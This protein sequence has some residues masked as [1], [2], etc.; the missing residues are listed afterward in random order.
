VLQRQEF[1]TGSKMLDNLFYDLLDR[2]SGI[3][4]KGEGDAFLAYAKEQYGLSNIAYLGVNIPHPTHGQHYVQCTY[5]DAWVKHYV[6]S[7]FVS[8]DPV[9]R[10]GLTS[11]IPLDWSEMSARIEN[12]RQVFRDAKDFGVGQ[13][14]LTFPVR[15]VHGETAIFSVNAELGDK[16]WQSFKKRALRDF[17]VIAHYFHNQ[18]LEKH[19]TPTNTFLELSDKEVECLKW[20]AVGKSTWDTSVILNISER[21]V[22]FYLDTARHKMN[23]LTKTQAVAKAVA[24]GIVNVS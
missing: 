11:L 17:H 16:E 19:G 15:G 14:G 5:S 8:I 20:A 1:E 24:L 12:S 7:D 3:E 18:V 6:T 21:T 13:Q 4:E 2:V 22:K 10:L 9:V 23:C